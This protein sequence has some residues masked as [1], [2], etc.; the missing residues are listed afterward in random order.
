LAEI[1][2]MKRTFVL[3][4]LCAALAAG[5]AGAVTITFDDQG[6]GP[7][8][9]VTTQYAGQGVTFE[10]Y[11]NTGQQVNVETADNTVFADNTPPSSP[12]SLSNFY[13]HSGANRADILRIIFSTPVSGISFQYDGAGSLGANTLFKIYGFG[14]ALLDSL[15]VAA[16]TD[17]SYHLVS[18]SDTGVSHIDIIS[19]SAGWGYYLDNLSF[20]GSSVPD[21]AS[22][23]LLL[24]SSL[25]LLAGFRRKLA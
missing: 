19:P 15:T 16:A 21:A 22:T 6:F 17:T 24:T 3:T 7:L 4:G 9:D 12:E 23:G 25:A 2:I 20:N 1:K 11:L 14:N 8:A 18:V 13:N 5:S 10:G